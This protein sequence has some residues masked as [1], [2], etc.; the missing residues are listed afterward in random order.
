MNHVRIGRLVRILRG[1][2][3]SR[4]GVVVDVVDA[5]RVVVENPEDSDRKMWRHVQ[6]VRNILP[7][8]WTLSISRNATSAAL[9]DGLQASKVMTKIQNSHSLK[10]I[11]GR[12]AL[13]EATDFERYLLRV[14]KRSRAHWSRVIFADR[15]ERMPVS[16]GAVLAK[17]LERSHKKNESRVLL[18]RQRR[19]QKRAAAKKLKRESAKKRASK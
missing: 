9:S 13:A 18:Q 11:R 7:L 15:D 12:E 14:A 5:N 19:A 8:K 1:P 2:R 6:N 4:I 10:R 16:H 3:A 17:K